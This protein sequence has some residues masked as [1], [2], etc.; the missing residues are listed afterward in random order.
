MGRTVLRSEEM[1]VAGLSGVEPDGATGGLSA[2]ALGVVG[3]AALVALLF[4]SVERLRRN[5]PL[6]EGN[7]L[8]ETWVPWGSQEMLAQ[9]WGWLRAAMSL[10]TDDVEAAAG[11]DAAMMV[12]FADLSMQVLS[13]IGLPLICILCPLHFFCGGS[14]DQDDPLSWIGMANVESGSWLCWVH[15]GIVWFVVIVVQHSLKRAQVGP[16]HDATCRAG[17]HN[18]HFP[19]RVYTCRF[20]P[21]LAFQGALVFLRCFKTRLLVNP[22]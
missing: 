12:E 9:K 14:I 18:A 22:P 13:I 1:N 4:R 2:L 6:H 15:S 7:L 19:E 16:G 8:R 17:W 10:N 20:Q 3:N 21:L 5:H 11:L